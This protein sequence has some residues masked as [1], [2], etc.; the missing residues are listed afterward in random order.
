MTY[1]T[2]TLFVGK[3]RHHFAQLASTNGYAT[4]LLSKNKPTEGTI[5]TT[6]YQVDGRGQIGNKWESEA[7]KNLT[8]SII[9]YPTFLQIRDQ[10][11]LNQAISLAVLD[12]T[13]NFTNNFVKVKWSNDIYVFNN[14]IAG[15][16][17]QNTL[18]GSKISTS[19][20]GIGLNINQ[21][22][23][24]SAPNPTS[25]KL[26]T[27]QDFDLNEMLNRL[28]WYIEC[29]Y[30]QLKAGRHDFLRQDYLQHLYRYAED[31]LYQ[32]PDGTI[33]SGKITGISPIGQLLISHQKGEE[34]FGFK[35]VKFV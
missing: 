26:E 25:L 20:V 6:D 12:F 34:A 27:A 8:F 35:E 13:I 19:I 1:L 7:R 21:T 23:F 22:E 14:K 32:R 33:F 11:L 15:I 30:L 16:L 3:V 9:L 29:R 24:Q 5:I 4:E 18:S 2:N 28:L 17:I 31:A 10:F